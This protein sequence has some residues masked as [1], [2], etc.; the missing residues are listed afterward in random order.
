MSSLSGG[1]Y[2]LFASIVAIFA[3][4]AHAT[5]NV[6]LL[7]PNGGQTLQQD[8][9]FII[10]WTLSGDSCGTTHRLELVR[11][12]GSATTISSSVSGNSHDW[13]I[14]SNEPATGGYR[15]RVTNLATLAS[16]SSDLGFTIGAPPATCIVTVQYPNGDELLQRGET[17]SVRW[18]VNG[19]T[20]GSSQQVLYL[21][22]EREAWVLCFSADEGS[23]EWR[24]PSDHAVGAGYRIFVADTASRTNDESDRPFTITTSSHICE[25]DEKQSRA[26]SLTATCEGRETR[27]CKHDGTGWNEWGVCSGAPCE[28][29]KLCTPNIVERQ[30][31]NQIG[32]CEGE[33]TR[34]CSF[35]GLKWG[36]WSECT[37][38]PCAQNMSKRASSKGVLY[39]SWSSDSPV[40]ATY[41]WDG[42]TK[43]SYVMHR[44]TATSPSYVVINQVEQALF[45]TRPLPDGPCS[46]EVGIVTDIY[47]DRDRLINTIAVAKIGTY[48]VDTFESVFGGTT[49]VSIQGPKF[50]LR[51]HGLIV[52]QRDSDC[53][54]VVFPFRPP[55]RSPQWATV[56]EP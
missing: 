49:D 56:V 11:F 26:C 7:A 50:T 31:C 36:P 51:T 23:C 30:P 17:H 54:I 39:W 15:V 12:D 16:D 55:Q 27:T 38:S 21:T 9:R 8:R 2:L 3:A 41:L 40:P 22:P 4:P 48:F 18:A 28:P 52:P 44:S 43:I 5:C 37:G 45:L 33:R 19:L 47:D 10:S 6:Q 14:P 24:I 29:E 25:P 53:R 35:D 13:L 32:G 34:R 20:C 1:G 46:F 42:F